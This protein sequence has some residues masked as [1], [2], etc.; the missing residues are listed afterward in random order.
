MHLLPE[1]RYPSAETARRALCRNQYVATPHALEAYT[2]ASVS[3]WPAIQ[4]AV[5]TFVALV[6]NLTLPE[7]RPRKRGAA[8]PP[9]RQTFSVPLGESVR[10]L[11][12]RIRRV[13][14]KSGWARRAAS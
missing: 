6:T 14:A 3:R 13:K 11:W 9:S 1:L 2:S 5:M 7:I 12:R 10:E 8:A 4:G